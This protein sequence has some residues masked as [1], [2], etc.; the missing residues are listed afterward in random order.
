M[1]GN[2]NEGPFSEPCVD[3]STLSHAQGSGSP[4]GQARLE[5][6]RPHRNPTLP[7]EAALSPLA[8]IHK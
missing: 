7:R 5:E 3:V 4:G 8:F 6:E 1:C 2:R